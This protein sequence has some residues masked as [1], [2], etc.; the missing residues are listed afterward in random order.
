MERTD[1]AK[2]YADGK[3]TLERAAMDTGVSVR[4]MMEYLKHRKIPAQ[5]DVKDLEKDNET[6]LS[7]NRKVGNCQRK[8]M[9][10]DL[11]GYDCLL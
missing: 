11:D 10:N 7:E 2:L 4:E 6:F 5:Y 1:A 9:V 8:R 3:V